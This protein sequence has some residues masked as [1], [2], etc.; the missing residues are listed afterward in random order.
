[1]NHSP[2]SRALRA[3]V[4]STAF[5]GAAGTVGVLSA[6]QA[7]AAVANK[8]SVVIPVEGMGCSGCAESLE[9]QIKEMRGVSKAVID[10]E[11]KE[12]RVTFNP[13]KVT[14]QELIAHINT[15]YSAG[16]PKFEGAS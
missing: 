4:V 7:Q 12:A 5:L 9:G 2:L 14:L 1:M 13:K 6:T 15:A 3:F 16:T 10:F 8:Q 11:A